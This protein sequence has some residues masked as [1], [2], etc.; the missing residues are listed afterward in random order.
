VAFLDSHHPNDAGAGV[1]D[2]PLPSQPPPGPIP[3]AS[4]SLL[5]RIFGGLLLA[6]LATEILFSLFGRHSGLRIG[7]GLSSARFYDRFVLQNLN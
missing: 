3:S 7:W 6:G 1:L 2:P 5:L 4:A